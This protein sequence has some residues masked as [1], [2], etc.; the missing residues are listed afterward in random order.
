MASPRKDTHCG[1]AGM[2]LIYIPIIHT[3]VDMADLHESIRQHTLHKMGQAA[4]KR[5]M[6]AIDSKGLE[7]SITQKA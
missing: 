6:K 5:K 3:Q 1:L 4:L 2:K 7:R